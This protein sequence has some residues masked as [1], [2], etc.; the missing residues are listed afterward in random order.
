MHNWPIRFATARSKD[1]KERRHVRRGRNQE[2]LRSGASRR[3]PGDTA[4]NEGHPTQEAEASDEGRVYVLSSKAKIARSFATPRRRR[5]RAIISLIGETLVSGASNCTARA[6]SVINAKA[7]AVRI[8]EIE[9]GKIAVKVLFPAML[10]DA[11]HTAL[12]DAVE[13]FDGVD[14]DFRAGC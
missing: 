9:L 5:F 7:N 14:V 4:A 13:A 6:L 12:E 2:A 1:D 10:I 3:S 8:S 11:D